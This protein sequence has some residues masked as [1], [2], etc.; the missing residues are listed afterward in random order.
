V[1]HQLEGSS[2]VVVLQ[3]A[4]KHTAMWQKTDAGAHRATQNRCEQLAR[5]VNSG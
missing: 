3:R 5:E 4:E 1:A 2:Q